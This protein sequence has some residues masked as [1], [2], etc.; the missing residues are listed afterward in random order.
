MPN[1][2]AVSPQIIPG[3]VIILGDVLRIGVA[4]PYV[5]VGKAPGNVAGIRSGINFQAVPDGAFDRQDLLFP[6][7]STRG[8]VYTGVDASAAGV[9]I[10]R[11]GGSRGRDFTTTTHTGTVVETTLRSQLIGAQSMQPNG[12]VGVSVLLT[13][14]AQGG[15]ATT[16]RLKFG[17]TTLFAPTRA[18]VD[19]LWWTVFGANKNA[20][21]SQ[22]WAE[23]LSWATLAN[24]AGLVNSALDT[25]LDQTLALTIQLG[26]VGDSWDVR[27][28]EVFIQPGN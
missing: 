13:A 4:A 14:N 3:G 21:G 24:G 5:Y 28:W 6:L 8:L 22:S 17:A 20:S 9:A 19:S 1:G 16:F 26:A 7:N 11:L 25:T 10:A 23:L 18:A 15:V 12:A 2:Y 27:L